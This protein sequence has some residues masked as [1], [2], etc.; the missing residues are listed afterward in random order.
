ME[1]Y[2]VNFISNKEI[3]ITYFGWLY[4]NESQ[5]CK[6]VFG[7]GENW[8]N[9]TTKEMNKTDK[10]FVTNI[11]LEDYKLLNFCFCNE[12]EQWDNNYSNDYSFEYVIKEEPKEP[13]IEPI[14]IEDLKPIF[15]EETINL[16]EIVENAGV[17]ESIEPI[18]VDQLKDNGV[19]LISEVQDKVILPYTKEEVE[20]ILEKENYDNAESVINDKFVKPY[21]EYKDLYR[22]R[23]R[24][25][26]KLLTEKEGYSMIEATGIVLK[27]FKKRYLHPAIISACKSLDELD[28]YLDCLAKNE[29]DDFKIFEIKYE[30]YPVE[31]KENSLLE[32]ANNIYKNIIETTKRVFEKVK[33]TKGGTTNI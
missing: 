30:L 5:S 28:V 32:K 11:E 31:V 16:E 9:T 33:T 20:K 8:H 14:S 29:L 10:G 25:T 13:E 15:I 19:L 7:F 12:N 3:E 18:D 21:A 22:A 17:V 26:Y 2:N 23:A 1:Q 4:Q 6:I 24:E 27:L